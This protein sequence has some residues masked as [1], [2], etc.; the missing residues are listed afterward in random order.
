MKSFLKFLNLFGR[1]TTNTQAP[2]PEKKVW[3]YPAVMSHLHEYPHL[4]SMKNFKVR[5]IVQENR[6]LTRDLE[7]SEYM[8]NYRRKI[9]DQEIQELLN[10]ILEM[11]RY[12]EIENPNIIA[13]IMNSYGYKVSED[14][15]LITKGEDEGERKT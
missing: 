5:E 10:A 3:Q 12:T 13:R 7:I 14:G 15:Y 2:D 9:V 4:C 1:I 6:Q 11:S 8:T